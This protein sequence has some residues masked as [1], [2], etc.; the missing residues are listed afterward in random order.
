M[1]DLHCPTLCINI[2][3]EILINLHLNQENG[4]A[5]VEMEKA[6]CRPASLFSQVPNG[7]S[8]GH[9]L[10][11]NRHC[12]CQCAVPTIPKLTIPFR[13]GLEMDSDV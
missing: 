4:P 12:Y 3:L 8:L 9:I 11:K 1:G 2:A 10:N 13:H 5:W 7:L 6:P